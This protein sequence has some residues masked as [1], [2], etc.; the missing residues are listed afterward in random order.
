M[1]DLASRI[2]AVHLQVARLV[3]E[4]DGWRK[5]V[6]AMEHELRE[7]H[8]NVEVLQARIAELER[9]NEVLRVTR[10]AQI[11]RPEGQVEAKQRIDE[12]VSE[13]D[14]CLALLTH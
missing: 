2:R 5:R 11:Q 8:R 14:R 10:P 4:R 3:A 6:A 7:H 9:E 1:S 13:I 12:L